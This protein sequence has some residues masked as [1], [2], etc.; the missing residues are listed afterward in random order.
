MH[1]PQFIITGININYL[2]DASSTRYCNS[3]CN[4]YRST[5]I[6]YTL[7]STVAAESKSHKNIT[8]LN[9]RGVRL[10]M[11]HDDTIESIN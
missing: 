6:I 1:L 2:P 7:N 3:K 4:V 9:V 5:C 8:W 10:A 11:L